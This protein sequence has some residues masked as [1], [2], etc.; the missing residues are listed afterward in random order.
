MCWTTRMISLWPQV[1][2]S[3]FKSVHSADKTR[4]FVVAFNCCWRVCTKKIA[5]IKE[6]ETLLHFHYDVE[7]GTSSTHSR[8]VRNYNTFWNSW[9]LTTNIWQ[10]FWHTGTRRKGTKERNLF[11]W[12]LKNQ[13]TVIC[14]MNSRLV[15]NRV[16][17]PQLWH[18]QVA[19]GETL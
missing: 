17:L 16:I 2:L 13:I 12:Q 9:W 11:Y 7:M 5:S 10:F 19:A 18:N 6:C 1:H 15:W 4:I 14:V 8:S 3:M